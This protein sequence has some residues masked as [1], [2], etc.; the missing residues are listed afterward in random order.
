[1]KRFTN[2]SGTV[3]STPT[4]VN[5]LNHPSQLPKILELAS[6]E[7]LTVRS[8]GAG[9]SFTA[10]V[11]TQG[12][13]LNLDGFQGLEEVDAI[14]HE[15]VFRAGTRL[16]QIPGLLKPFGL[17]LENMGDIDRQSIAGAISTAT[18]G[19]GLGFTG[20]S[21]QVTGLKL[22]LAD[23]SFVRASATE[24][25]EIFQAARVGLGAIGIITHVRLR[26]VPEYLLHS[27]ESI[28][29]LS[30]IVES[31]VERSKNVD[32]LEFFWF[33]GTTKALVKTNTRL[34]SS[35]A[36]QAPNKISQWIND[37]LLSNASLQL[38]CSLGAAQPRLIPTLNTLA[39]KVLSDREL[40]D[41]WHKIYVSPRRVK[42]SEME[43]ALPLERFDE[44][45]AEL[46]TY[47]AKSSAPVVFPVEVRTAG[48]DDTW[49][50]TAS[51]RPSV[52]IAV[53]RYIRDNV[54]HLFDDVEK[55]LRS[56]GGRPHWGKEH[57]L[58]MTDL[59]EIY[60]RFTD[61]QR[62]RQQVDPTGLMLNPYLRTLLIG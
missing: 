2:F 34:E 56:F 20:F 62:V 17:A 1:M 10:L 6:A 8:V 11:Q 48:A 19:T 58:V 15:V 41:R 46:Q 33:P 13:L 43:Y 42:F 45:F 57:S 37:E 4:Q 32:H 23:G 7:G 51:G 30:S 27:V 61:F 59:K 54:P 39:T 29:R 14:T 40:T 31:F 9:H 55:I 36:I 52:Y 3:T 28:E 22:V 18:H 47:F 35:A 16:W 50:G 44:A 21:G 5:S 24:N 49:L 12:I 53:H 26:C 38:L 25:A 60:P